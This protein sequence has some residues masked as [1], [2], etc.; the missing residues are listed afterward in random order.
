VN[1]VRRFLLFWLA[2]LVGGVLVS[3][4]P[5]KARAQSSTD[6]YLY[7]F[8]DPGWSPH[9]GA[10]TTAE[11]VT[12]QAACNLTAAPLIA[13][14]T[15]P[16]ITTTYS[17]ASGTCTR[18]TSYFGRTDVFPVISRDSGVPNVAPTLAVSVTDSL[19]PFDLSAADG[20]LVAYA[21]VGV[22]SIAFGV[23]A[24]MRV[25]SDTGRGGSWEE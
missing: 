18:V 7:S 22:W 16:T 10:F 2:F 19:A 20:L 13:I 6:L 5:G 25:M 11:T 3:L 14:S 4:V 12:P 8:A 17:S 1:D 24:V 9:W 23:V 21:I 15:P